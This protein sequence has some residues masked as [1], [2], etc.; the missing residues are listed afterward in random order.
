MK[1]QIQFLEPWQPAGERASSFEAQLAH[2]VGL[3]HPLFFR[4]M[5]AIARRQDCDNVLDPGL[6]RH[7]LLRLIEEWLEQMEAD[8]R[9]FV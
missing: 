3:R 2:E 8:H 9:A 4:T 1:L 6:S 7:R 5:R